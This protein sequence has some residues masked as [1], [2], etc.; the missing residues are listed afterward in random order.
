[1]T[2]ERYPTRAKLISAALLLP[3][4]LFLTAVALGYA[5]NVQGVRLPFD[6]FTTAYLV[7]LNRLS[8]LLNALIVLGPVVAVLANLIPFIRRNVQFNVGQEL[9]TIH[10]TRSSLLPL[11]IMVIGLGL[12]AIFF[13]YFLAENW[14]CIIGAKVHC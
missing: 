14:Q 13:S 6:R 12:A 10:I 11:A 5:F 9:V 1:M 7:P 2:I 3:G 8:I 4:L